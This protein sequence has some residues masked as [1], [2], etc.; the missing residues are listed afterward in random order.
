MTTQRSKDPQPHVLGRTTDDSLACMF[1]KRLKYEPVEPATLDAFHALVQDEHVRR[2]LMDGNVFSREWSK[3]RIRDSQARFERRG[4]GIWLVYDRKTD[5]LVGFCGFLEVPS[6]HPEPQLVYAMF[7]R[8]SGKGYATEMAR[9]SIAQA[10]RQPDFSEIF[11][12]VDEVNVASCRVLEKLGF[13]RIATQQGSFG[14]MFLL[15]L[16]G[17]ASDGSRTGA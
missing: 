17:E 5:E 13:K 9:T 1:S 6:I 14:R 11:A 12:A 10:R 2:Y 3:D 15:R 8:F 4:V 7:E 16:V